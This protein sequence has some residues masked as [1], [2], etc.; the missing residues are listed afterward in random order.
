MYTIQPKISK[1][2]IFKSIPQEQVFEKY[3]NIRVQLDGLICSPLRRDKR[4]TCGF[5][6]SRSG[7]LYFRDFGGHFWGNCVDLVMHLYNVQYTRAL[8]IIAHDFSLRQIELGELPALVSRFT[9]EDIKHERARFEISWRKYERLDMLYWNKFHITE[10]DL[11]DLKVAPVKALWINGHL[12][13]GYNS[14]DP[15]Y[16]IVLAPGEY[17]VYF[18]YSQQRRFLCN[19]SLV[20]G[21][22]QLPESGPLVIITKSFKDILVLRKFNVPAVSWQGETIVPD[23]DSIKALR[24]R[25]ERVYSLYDFDLAGI[26]TAN[27][28]RKRYG[29]H[30]LFF[31]NGRF[32]YHDCQAKDAAEYI[33][34]HGIEGGKQ[35]YNNFFKVM[36]DDQTSPF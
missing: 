24:D 9:P 27:K 17:K 3:L 25:F 28:M 12:N 16:A 31:T 2:S 15:A 26:R 35:L 18:P 1:D 5:K 22:E 21:M 6:Y 34:K 19:T 14:Y 8:E 29:I 10:Q 30:P 23:W 32:G 13:Y 33:E 4:P 20:M 11:Y 36:I 7:V